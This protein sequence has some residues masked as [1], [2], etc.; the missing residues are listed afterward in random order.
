MLSLVIQD[1]KKSIVGRL[2]DSPLFVCMAVS[3]MLKRDRLPRDSAHTVV[4]RGDSLI[5]YA[6]SNNQ[7]LRPPADIL[8]RGLDLSLGDF[9]G[10]HP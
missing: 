5:D 2:W 10:E 1:R 7:R 3:E 6:A 4:L 9:L 8:D